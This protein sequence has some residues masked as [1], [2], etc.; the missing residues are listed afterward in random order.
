MTWDRESTLTY[1]TW[2]P[3]EWLQALDDQACD[4]SGE[5][6]NPCWWVLSAL[7]SFEGKEAREKMYYAKL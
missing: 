3:A 5:E 1:A 2:S 4:P 6:E 7:E